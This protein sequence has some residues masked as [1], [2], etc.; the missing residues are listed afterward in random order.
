MDLGSELVNYHAKDKIAHT[1][2][3]KITDDWD[4]KGSQVIGGNG[5]QNVWDDYDKVVDDK[6]GYVDSVYHLFCI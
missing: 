5:R 4:F 3:S 6:Y 1:E 2:A